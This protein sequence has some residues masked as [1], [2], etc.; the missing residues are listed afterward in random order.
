MD[1][2]EL[3]SGKHGS[4]ISAPIMKNLHSVRNSELVCSNPNFLHRAFSLVE[5]L[6]AIAIIGIV[7]FLAIPNLLKIKDDGEKNLAISRAEA[8]NM[9]MASYLQANGQAAAVAAWPADDDDRYAA[10]TPYV[11]FAPADLDDYLPAGY[12]VALP[13]ALIPLTK[14]TLSKGGTPFEY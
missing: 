12:T 14:A 10:L 11:A 4:S 2:D 5:V 3:P 13:S 9:A 8:L 1:H 7:T 6:A